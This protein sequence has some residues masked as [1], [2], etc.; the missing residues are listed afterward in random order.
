MGTYL[1]FKAKHGCEDQVNQAYAAHWG[2]VKHWLVYSDKIV[3]VAI[4]CVKSLIKEGL[5]FILYIP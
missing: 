3:E 2:D 4:R 5:L 1:E